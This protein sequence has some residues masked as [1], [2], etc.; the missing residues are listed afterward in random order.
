MP[1][2]NPTSDDIDKLSIEDKLTDKLAEI[3]LKRKEDV[4]NQ[5]AIVLGLDYVDLM[6]FAISE[7]ALRFIDK[8]VAEEK[9]VICFYKDDKEA[10]IATPDPENSETLA[11]FEDFKKE[12]ETINMKLYVISEKSFDIGLKSYARLPR[13][14][15]KVE[16]VAIT[17]NDLKQFDQKII[18][19]TDLEQEVKH[20]SVTDLVALVISAALKTDASDIHFEPEEKSVQL[21]LRIDGVLQNVALVDSEMWIKVIS[22][23]KLLAGLKLNVTDR[24]QDGRFTIFLTDD[25]IDVR[26]SCLPT[27]YGES[28]VMRLLRSTNAGLDFEKLGVRGI[29]FDQLKKEIG[30]P[31]GMIITTG[32]TGSG[33]TTTL[34]SILSKLNQPAVKIITLED[35]IEYKLEGI[36]QSQVDPTHGYS[37][38][39]G[40]KSILR[41]DPDIV[42]V[43]EI[44][45][46]DTADTAINAAL[47]G[48]LVLS[49]LHTNNA[50]ASIPRFLSMGVKAFLLAPSIN[51]IIG[52]RLARRICPHCKQ[53]VE[54]SAEEMQ[55]VRENLEKISA[56]SGY[57]PDLDNLKFYKGAGCEKCGGL[58]Y[59]GR[60]GLYELLTMNPEIEKMILDEKVSE[61]EIEKIAIENG[62]ITMVQ[63]GLLKALDGLT[64]VEE[65]FRVI[66]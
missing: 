37:F 42:M 3:D 7:D 13:I 66:E 19:I 23:I 47:T 59:K 46:L 26:V 10:R 44:R 20:V 6:G 1:Q 21:R 49:T 9:R 27:A 25:K 35:P 57:R 50:A 36:N 45:D 40:L 29:A 41:Q 54:L 24:P 64:S 60:V 38:A 33:K 48:H 32:P 55:K 17:E 51:A 4:A 22:R 62:M 56:K 53:E 34:Y 18:K 52:Q 28:V 12:H 8:T 30:R 65:V 39:T 14:T 63:D 2:N 11:W 58:G 16:G 31:N 43:G 5:K 61:Y 15:P